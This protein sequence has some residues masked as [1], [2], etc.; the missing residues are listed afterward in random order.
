VQ[1]PLSVAEPLG[2]HAPPGSLASSPAPLQFAPAAG[3]S[4]AP[5][6]R[7]SAEFKR[8]L[9]RAFLIP[10]ILLTLLAGALGGGVALLVRQA[11]LTQRSDQVLARSARLRELLVDRE[12][13]L[14]GYLLS[15]DRSFLLPLERADLRLTETLSRLR[16][17]L[18]EHPDQLARLDVVESMAREWARYGARERELFESGD[19]YI[20]H[21]KTGEGVQRLSSMLEVLDALGESE[22]VRRRERAEH[23]S[24]TG[25]LLFWLSLGCVTSLALVLGYASRRQLLALA[26]SHDAAAAEMLE[27]EQRI[28]ELNASLEQRVAERTEALAA[29]NAE[30]EAFTSSVSHDLRAPLRQL[31]GFTRLLDESAGARL[32]ARERSY[33]GLLRSTAA[34]AVQMV[35]DLLS[36]SRVSRTELR[37]LAV[38]LN[39]VVRSA[40][41]VLLHEQDG[42]EVEW[43]V[44]SLPGVQGDPTM[45]LLVLRNLLGNALKYT[46]QRRPARIEVGTVNVPGAEDIVYVRDNGVGF[47]MKYAHKL[48][49]VFQR[50][51]R[52]DEFE[53]TGIGLAH[54]RRIVQRHGGR[55]WGVG[56]PG[57]GAT[58]Y[59]ALPRHGQPGDVAL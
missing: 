5:L 14:R 1:T 2:E 57:Q 54:V 26:Q 50:L 27:R 20:H 4:V 13:G 31:G 36:F 11:R 9:T 3:A 37:S 12:T 51:H 21:F 8:L 6:A 17:L 10:A 39:A 46:R 30:L 49:G 53:G 16:Q 41:E 32:D 34:E 59:V 48:F 23:A 24:L 40:R 52:A 22:Q 47:D 45:L 33:L 28:R 44:H 58:F 56:V 43:V 18:A 15:G 19:D 42:R 55:V 7:E 35:D 29:V 38:D 25:S